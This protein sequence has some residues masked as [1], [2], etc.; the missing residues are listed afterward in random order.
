M[1]SIW[2][3][4]QN[5]FFQFAHCRA[6]VHRVSEKL[7]QCYFLNNSVEHWPILIFLA[8]NI[9]EKLDIFNLHFNPLTLMRLLHYLVKC[10]SRILA[11]IQRMHTGK[12]VRQLRNSYGSV[13][14]NCSP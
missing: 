11:V 13:M 3:F 4:Y 6:K 5:I 7:F 8:R 12:S 1:H 2:D 10:R 9:K 14:K